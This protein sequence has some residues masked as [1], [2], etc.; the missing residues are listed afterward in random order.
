MSACNQHLKPHLLCP[1]PTSVTTMT[2][3]VWMEGEVA[4]GSGTEEKQVLSVR[5][6]MALGKS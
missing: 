1:G 5:T 3:Q 4:A 6:A 2:P